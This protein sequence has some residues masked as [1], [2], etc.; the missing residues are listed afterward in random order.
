M[1]MK[2]YFPEY[3]RCNVDVLRVERDSAMMSTEPTSRDQMRSHAVDNEGLDP[4]LLTTQRN[5]Q[6][7][8]ELGRDGLAVAAE[9]EALLSF[10]NG[11]HA[12]VA[13]RFD[14]LS[15]PRASNRTDAIKSSTAIDDGHPFGHRLCHCHE[16]LGVDGL[17]HPDLESTCRV[18]HRLGHP[19]LG[20]PLIV[21]TIGVQS[22]GRRPE[23]SGV[24]SACWT[25]SLPMS[26]L[27]AA[28]ARSAPLKTPLERIVPFGGG[29]TSCRTTRSCLAATLATRWTFASPCWR[30][31]SATA[32]SFPF[33]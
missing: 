16:G 3:W 24:R 18:G 25:V 2:R 6:V 33:H 14:R 19:V 12:S 29:S 28:S 23:A 7:N 31:L 22:R 13:R 30:G 8:C 1:K 21:P 15:R 11:W 10:N 5:R 17:V 26:F 4:S 27:T 32:L 20:R 9:L